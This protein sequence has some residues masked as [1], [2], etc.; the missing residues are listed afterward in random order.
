[1]T[2]AAWIELRDLHI[3]AVIGTYGPDDVVP[4]ANILDLT[5]T[6]AHELVHITE[7]KMAL[8]FDYDPLITKIEKIARDQ[9]YETQEYLA[10]LISQLCASFNQN[11]A[12]EIC[13]RK[14]PVVDGTGSLGVRIVFEAEDMPSLRNHND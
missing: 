3:P 4:E 1:M 8:V 5:L 2:R 12:L 13:L 10:T 7:D 11:I 14:R 6:V 9:K